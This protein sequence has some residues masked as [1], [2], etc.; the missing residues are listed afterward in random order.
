MENNLE[1]LNNSNDILYKSKITTDSIIY[2]NDVED[3][4]G[5]F[6]I[7]VHNYN[8]NNNYYYYYYYCYYD[9]FCNSQIY[10]MLKLIILLI[11]I[12]IK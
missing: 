12:M 5:G 2:N 10:Y 3:H 9:Y 7:D 8:N 11:I 1:N 6:K 4:I